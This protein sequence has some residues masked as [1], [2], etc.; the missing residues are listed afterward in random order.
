MNI[1]ELRLMN[2]TTILYL[3]NTKQDY[4]RNIIIGKILEDEACFFKMEQDDA[5]II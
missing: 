3:K 2:D 5:C 1:K 4:R